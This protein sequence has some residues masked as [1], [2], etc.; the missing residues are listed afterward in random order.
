M[1]GKLYLIPA[2][3]GSENPN[4][5]F[6]ELNKIIIKNLKYFIVEEERSARR[7]LKKMNPELVIDNL[8]FF[9]LNEHTKPN[10]INN[11][12]HP[13]TEHS[14]GLISEAGVP[15]IA[16]PGSQVVKIAHDKDIEVVPLIGP[17]SI[18]LAMMSSGLNGQSFAFN[19]YLPIQQNERI[20]ML[21]KYENRSFTYNQTQ[22]FIEAPYRNNQLLKDI[23]TNCEPQTLLCV[24]CELTL[25]TQNIKTQS[26]HNWKANI[27]D[28][29]KHPSIFIIKKN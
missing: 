24:A 11:F 27:P 22:I 1:K 26:I 19:G 29:N 21:K 7:F 25:P 16:D 9:V 15:C 14:I 2:F 18:L 6:P 20:K 23:I 3:L 8:K 28:I 4:E 10:E 12:F 17:S 5:V 13:F